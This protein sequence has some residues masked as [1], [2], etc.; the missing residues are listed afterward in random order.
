MNDKK[1]ALKESGQR[2]LAWMSLALN[3]GV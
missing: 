2:I 3:P 1:L